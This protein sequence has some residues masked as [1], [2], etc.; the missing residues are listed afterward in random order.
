M[1]YKDFIEAELAPYL[2]VQ[3]PE[4]RRIAQEV[5][6]AIRRAV[7]DNGKSVVI[8]QFG[9]FH[10]VTTKSGIRKVGKGT[11]TVPESVHV[12]FRSAKATKERAE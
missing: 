9:T 7:L 6:S 11:I 8:P 12:R 5:F 10:P 4:A 3:P 2:A 1:T